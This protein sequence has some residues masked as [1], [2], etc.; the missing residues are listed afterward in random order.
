MCPLTT[1]INKGIPSTSLNRRG[2]QIKFLAV[3][4]SVI[5]SNICPAMNIRPPVYLMNLCGSE[6]ITLGYQQ[7][8]SSVKRWVIMCFTCYIVAMH[9][10]RQSSKQAARFDVIR[11]M[12]PVV[13]DSVQ[14][15]W[16]LAC[17]SCLAYMASCR[18]K[19]FSVE[20]TI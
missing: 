8:K 20:R 3:Y 4:L 13:V 9:D 1:A 7:L 19:Q 2:L 16:I 11:R 17:E 12:A 14:C 5:L 10:L 18:Q 6:L 15:W